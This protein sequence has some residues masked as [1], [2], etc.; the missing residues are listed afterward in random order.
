MRDERNFNCSKTSPGSLFDMSRHS[1]VAFY[2]NEL[3][4]D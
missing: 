2:E 4:W 1:K 3:D